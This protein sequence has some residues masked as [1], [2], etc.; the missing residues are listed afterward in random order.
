MVVVTGGASGIG[1]VCCRK[2]LEAGAQVVVLDRSSE[3]PAELRGKVAGPVVADI[4]DEDEMR[5]AAARIEDEI[6]PVV[7]LTNCAA[8][9]Q[10]PL[11]PNELSMK[12]FDDIVRV[13]QR[14]TYVSCLVFGE[15]MLA[16]GHG[17]IVNFASTAALRSVP[18]H[19]YA[20]AKAAVA[21]MTECLAGEWGPAGVRVNAV[22]PGYT[23]T[24]ATRARIEKGE[25]DP[26]PLRENAV[27]GRLVEPEEVANAVVFLASPLSSGITGVNVPVD[28]GW[29]LAPS[30]QT[31][32]GLRRP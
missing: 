25:R 22:S 31:Y 30:W 20:P 3:L 8:I 29:L 1:A 19:A 6:G 12:E 28:C 7:A 13:D 18:L 2:F 15:A 9:M 27:L 32:G 16:R 5:Q 14:G 24:P 17:S 21:S 26:A 11:R 4:S 23:N 10:G